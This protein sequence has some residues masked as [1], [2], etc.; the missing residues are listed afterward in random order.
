MR[1]LDGETDPAR[2]ERLAL[3][4]FEQAVLAEGRQLDDPAAFVARLNELLADL[5]AQSAARDR[6]DGATPA[7]TGV[8]IGARPAFSKQRSMRAPW[9]GRRRRP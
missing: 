1:R 5:G 8:E 6:V 9:A 3:L 2:F 7:S 4:L